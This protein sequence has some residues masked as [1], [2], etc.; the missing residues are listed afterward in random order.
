M[1]TQRV[2]LGYSNWRKFSHRPGQPATVG[3]VRCPLVG[4]TA[5]YRL[6]RP[7][8][9]PFSS[10]SMVFIRTDALSVSVT[11]RC[12]VKT[13]GRIGLVFDWFYR[14]TFI[15]HWSLLIL[16]RPRHLRCLSFSWQS[17]HVRG[18]WTEVKLEGLSINRTAIKISTKGSKRTLAA[19]E[20]CASNNVSPRGTA[21]RY[22]S[23]RWQ[24]DG[25]KN[26]GGRVRTSLVAG[27]G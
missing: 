24:F 26:R 4:D 21:R 13:V 2:C 3:V 16:R 6:H 12:C 27:G 9:T 18:C 22:A 8:L 14:R 1:W 15:R 17:R 19:S 10:I 23:R 5:G 11:S 20:Q 25:G 7:K